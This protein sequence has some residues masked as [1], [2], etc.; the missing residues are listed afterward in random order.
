MC[1]L[2]HQSLKNAFNGPWGTILERV[3]EDRYA[4]VAHTSSRPQEKGWSYPEMLGG[5][6]SRLSHNED[7]VLNFQICNGHPIVMSTE[8]ESIE[9]FHRDLYIAVQILK[10]LNII[11]RFHAYPILIGFKKS[12]L[13]LLLMIV[14]LHC[15]SFYLV[16]D[17]L[18][19]M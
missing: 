8:E 6:M 16:Q 2:M 18:W 19:L 17:V 7:V 14:W 12:F 10:L 5:L 9:G 1:H 4:P 11:R 15:E 13:A 3:D